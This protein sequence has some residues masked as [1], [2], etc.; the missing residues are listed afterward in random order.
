M[1]LT[2]ELILGESNLE[3]IYASDVKRLQWKDIEW[4]ARIV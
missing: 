4:A 3:G 2:E 1:L